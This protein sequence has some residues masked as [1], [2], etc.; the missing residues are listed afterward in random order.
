MVHGGVCPWEKGEQSRKKCQKYGFR[1]ASE[2]L[3]ISDGGSLRS[4]NTF[5]VMTSSLLAATDQSGSQE[6]VSGSRLAHSE[7]PDAKTVDAGKS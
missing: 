5:P 2:L 1:L 3:H 6:W 7:G 4:A